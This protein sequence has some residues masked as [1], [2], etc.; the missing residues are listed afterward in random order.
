MR[1]FFTLFLALIITSTAGAQAARIFPTVVACNGNQFKYQNYSGS[2]TIGE[3]ITP[4]LMGADS[5]I[6][7]QG[8]HQVDLP[9]NSVIREELDASQ[10]ILVYPN[11]T[12]GQV[13][14]EISQLNAKEIRVDLVDMLGRV[15]NTQKIKS[16]WGQLVFDLS[17]EADSYYFLRATTEDGKSV[18]TYK[19]QKIN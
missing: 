6:L 5:V 9:L 2:F 16:T 7:T 12:Q 8:F 10:E 15:L 18:G 19:V 17:Q 3:M 4:T 1:I 13:I 11:P 14:F